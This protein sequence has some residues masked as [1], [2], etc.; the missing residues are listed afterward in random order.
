MSDTKTPK[1][2]PVNL[3]I[4]KSSPTIYKD[5]TSIVQRTRNTKQYST[6]IDLFDPEDIITSQGSKTRKH[7]KP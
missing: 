4:E 5:G 7:K 1:R 2:K 3:Q 6:T